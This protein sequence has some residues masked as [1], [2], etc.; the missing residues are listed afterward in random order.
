MYESDP[1]F[2]TPPDELAIWWYMD[3][4]RFLA[5]VKNGSLYF[6]RKHELDDPWEGV[7]PPVGVSRAIDRF[8]RSE[9]N[10]RF[11]EE[12]IHETGEMVAARAVVTCWHANP[13][14][15]VAMWR[16]Y[17]TGAE[18][19]AIQ[20]TVG[21][22]KKALEREPCSTKIAR[23]RYIDHA[24]DDVGR[25]WALNPLAPLFCKRKGF[26]HEQEVRCVIANPE[27]EREQALVMSELDP[28]LR[29]KFPVI[30]QWEKIADGD[31]GESGLTVPADL[32]ALIEQIVV[33]PR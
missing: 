11:L 7:V 1:A 26:E 17:T 5:L 21:R 2:E 18:G 8:S 15:S 30:D 27:G 23:V 14:E 28:A 12:S 9:E 6:C 10:A 24:E 3:V 32:N 25:D 22:L 33:S 20:S 19:V 16:L 4:G 31:L 29:V 13:R